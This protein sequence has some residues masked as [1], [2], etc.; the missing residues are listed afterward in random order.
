VE[1]GSERYAR[2][3]A[4]LGDILMTDA[5]TGLQLFI[6][7]QEEYMA[8]AEEKPEPKKNFPEEDGFTVIDGGRIVQV[9][10]NIDYDD[11]FNGDWIRSSRESND[12]QAG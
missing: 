2:I 1:R 5:L 6:K 7:Q 12:D 3:N 4:F 11:G 8:K 10:S 9:H